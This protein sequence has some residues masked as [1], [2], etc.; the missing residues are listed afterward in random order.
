MAAPIPLDAPV[1]SAERLLPDSLIAYPLWMRA[2]RDCV[3]LTPLLDQLMWRR[4]SAMNAAVASA[5]FSA[6]SPE[7]APESAR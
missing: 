2:P 7:D 6:P 1:T 3:L 4:P 5:A